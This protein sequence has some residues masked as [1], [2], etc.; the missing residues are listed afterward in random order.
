MLLKEP[1]GILCCRAMPVIVKNIYAAISYF[2]GWEVEEELCRNDMMFVPWSTDATL[3]ETGRKRW[4]GCEGPRWIV[5]TR[6]RRRRRSSAQST[7]SIAG[8]PTMSLLSWH[9]RRKPISLDRVTAVFMQKIDLI[10][11]SDAFGDYM[12]TQRFA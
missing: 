3:E 4:S 9:G 2:K 12:Q 8:K 5:P 1:R 11:A 7:V 6:A 10:L